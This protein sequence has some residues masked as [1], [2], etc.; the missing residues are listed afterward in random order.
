M[1]IMLLIYVMAR[2]F[3]GS[4]VITCTAAVVK[5]AISVL[6][7]SIHIARSLADLSSKA[8]VIAATCFPAAGTP[9]LAVPC[10]LLEAGLVLNDTINDIAPITAKVSD[11]KSMAPALILKIQSCPAVVQNAI[12][13]VNNLLN[14]SET[15]VN[16]FVSSSA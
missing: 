7:D 12:T 9:V 11:I 15:C 5:Q 1:E 8:G 2:V 4:N 10:V 13:K 14:T 6:L 3:T 16:N